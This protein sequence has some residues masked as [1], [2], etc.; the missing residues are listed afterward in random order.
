MKP[1]A[2]AMKIDAEQLEAL[3]AYSN[4]TKIPLTAALREAIDLWLQ[5]RASAQIEALTRS[6]VSLTKTS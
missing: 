3:R 6:S 5:T 1:K 4:V 2:T